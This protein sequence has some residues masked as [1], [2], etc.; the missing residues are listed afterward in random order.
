MRLAMFLIWFLKQLKKLLEISW[1]GV[2]CSGGQH[3]M[4]LHQ[5]QGLLK[6]E[7]ASSESNPKA[8]EKILDMIDL[9]LAHR[10]ME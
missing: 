8:R 10:F 9:M 4:A 2:T 1:R 3:G 6:R 7:Y 5:L